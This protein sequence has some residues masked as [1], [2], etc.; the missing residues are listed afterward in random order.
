LDVPRHAPLPSVEVIELNTLRILHEH[1]YRLSVFCRSC[2][3]HRFL[4]LTVLIDAGQ[5]ERAV[6]GLRVRCARCGRRG[7]LC[8]S[9]TGG[10]ARV[11]CGERG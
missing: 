5:G 2:G 9:G 11:G 8:L 7:E 6:V 1:G 3:R 4:D 10:T